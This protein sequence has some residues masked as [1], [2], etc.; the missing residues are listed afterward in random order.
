MRRPLRVY[1]FPDS[2]DQ[3]YC[4]CRVGASSILGQF[5]EDSSDNVV[6]VIVVVQYIVL[7]LTRDFDASMVVEVAL[8]ETLFPHACGVRRKS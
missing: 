5:E 8:E 6:T 4:N 2:N 1:L 7:P 3:R